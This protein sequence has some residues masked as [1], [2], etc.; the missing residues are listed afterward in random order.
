[1]QINNYG[2]QCFRQHIIV[3]CIERRC[4]EC[5]MLKQQ[6]GS[7]DYMLNWEL[8]G[9]ELSKRKQEVKS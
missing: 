9:Q 8:A 1:M 4:K 5:D 2:R 3:D 7:V 6:V